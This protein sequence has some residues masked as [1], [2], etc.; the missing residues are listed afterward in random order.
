M[1]TGRSSP[2][3][4]C[5]R[6]RVP[7]RDAEPTT[8]NGSVAWTI[9]RSVAR[10]GGP[11]SAGRVA[12]AGN[13]NS[14]HSGTGISGWST[15]IVPGLASS[16]RCALGGREEA[17]LGP[18]RLGRVEPA[19][20]PD[21]RV[22]HDPPLDLAR[23]LLRAD[24][25]HAQRPAA[26]GDVEQHLLDRAGA[27]ARRVLVQLVEHHEQQRLGGAGL[28]LALELGPQR[29]ADHEPLRPVRQV[30]QVDHGDLGALGGV[31]LVRARSWPGRRGSAGPGP[32]CWP[33]SR[34]AN[35]LTV[36]SPTDA[37][38][39]AAPGSRRR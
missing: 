16:A 14:T 22:G 35:A 32:S 23:G 19:D 17:V 33:I 27:L 8:A 31:D 10:G 37:A 1:R 3:T 29:H 13:G 4:G 20:H 6:R 38:G 39:P 5:R 30:V 34:R 36:P 18:R 28:L 2:R 11:A 25:D 26:L 7:P 24:Q 15:N 21:R 9:E 12:Q